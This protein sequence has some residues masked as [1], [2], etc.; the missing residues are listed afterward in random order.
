MAPHLNA[1]SVFSIA[2]ENM[3]MDVKNFLMSDLAVSQKKVNSL[4]PQPGRT[5][6]GRQT[7]AYLEKTATCRGIQVRKRG[8]MGIGND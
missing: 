8:C 3:E 6:C 2:G 5:E 4:T 1:E 7:L